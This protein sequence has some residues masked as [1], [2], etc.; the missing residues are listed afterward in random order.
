MQDCGKSNALAMPLIWN[1]FYHKTIWMSFYQSPSWLIPSGLTGDPDQ[2]TDGGHI[3]SHLD[4]YSDSIYL[5]L[6]QLLD[7]EMAVGSC[8]L[9]NDWHLYTDMEKDWKVM[10]LLK[11]QFSTHA[12]ILTIQQE[13]ISISEKSL[14]IW[15]QLRVHI[16]HSILPAS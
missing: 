7:L 6:R 4:S 5:L 3:N 16:V 1:I 10:M 2:A 15:H 11:F 9:Q 12:R 13:K 8:V 14:G